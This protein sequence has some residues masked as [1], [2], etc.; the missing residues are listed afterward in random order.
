[1]QKGHSLVRLFEALAPQFRQG[2]QEAYSGSTATGEPEL[3]QDALANYDR[4]FEN[5]RYIFEDGASLGGGS[6]NTLVALAGVVGG[7][8]DRLLNRHQ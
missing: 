4:I 5:A 8:V 7:Y 1:M 3:I 2:L 6:I